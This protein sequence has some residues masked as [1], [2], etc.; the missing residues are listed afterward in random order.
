MDPKGV[1]ELLNQCLED[2]MGWMGANKLKLNPDK[3]KVL[4]IGSDS[5]LRS[6]YTPRVVGVSLIPK[7]SVY[8]LGVL[9]DQVLVL[10]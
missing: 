2:V 7:P 3:T 8:N 9:F 6:G 5:I 4:L 1:G 10:F